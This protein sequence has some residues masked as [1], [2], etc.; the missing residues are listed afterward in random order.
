MIKLTSK[1]ISVYDRK[2]SMRLTDMEW[3]ILD[4]ICRQEKIRRKN[5]LELIA[6][7]HSPQIGFTS[8]VR[9][10]TLIYMYNRTLHGRQTLSTLQKSLL[11]LR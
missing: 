1:V 10:F 5:I 8:S 6:E 11:S 9:L 3:H 7:S 2:T 4:M